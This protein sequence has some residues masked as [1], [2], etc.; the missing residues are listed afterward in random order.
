MTRKH[1][2]PLDCKFLNDFFCLRSNVQPE[3][4]YVTLRYLSFWYSIQQKWYVLRHLLPARL[5]RTS[6]LFIPFLAKGRSLKLV[7]TR[8]LCKQT[9]LHNDSCVNKTWS[10]DKKGKFPKARCQSNLD[11]ISLIAADY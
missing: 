9:C 7:C 1:V 4:A 3:C 2:L 11:I 10:R 8:Q 5:L 6:L